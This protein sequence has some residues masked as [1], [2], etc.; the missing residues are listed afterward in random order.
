MEEIAYDNGRESRSVSVFSG[1][2]NQNSFGYDRVMG[3]FQLAFIPDSFEEVS[4]ASFRDGLKLSHS[5]LRLIGK[6]TGYGSGVEKTQI[7]TIVRKRGEMSSWS[8]ALEI[9]IP[10]RV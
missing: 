10:D 9:H 8:E 2:H 4:E 3:V 5:S 7:P 6:E 1:V